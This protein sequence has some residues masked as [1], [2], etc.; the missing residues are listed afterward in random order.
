[1][2]SGQM[3]GSH[4]S[5][6]ELIDRGLCEI[7]PR[8]G[9]PS[10]TSDGDRIEFSGRVKSDQANFRHTGTL[11]FWCSICCGA[12]RLALVARPRAGMAT[13]TVGDGNDRT[14]FE[15]QTSSWNWHAL[16]FG[17]LPPCLTSPPSV[18]HSFSLVCGYVGSIISCCGSRLPSSASSSRLAG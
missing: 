17:K 10:G 5:M 3:S 6:V 16:G 1:M 2:V 13:N 14:L 4:L 12:A 9:Q 7:Q 15:Y 11:S 18:Q 8:H